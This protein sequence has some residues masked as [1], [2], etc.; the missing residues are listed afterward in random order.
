MQLKVILHVYSKPSFFCLVELTNRKPYKWVQDTSLLL[1]RGI[2]KLCLGFIRLEVNNNNINPTNL[3]SKAGPEGTEQYYYW[4]TL[5]M[6]CAWQTHLGRRKTFA[7]SSNRNLQIQQLLSSLVQGFWEL[8][9]RV[10]V[11]EGTWVSMLWFWERALLQ[12][13]SLNWWMCP[14]FDWSF[15]W[16]WALLFQHRHQINRKHWLKTTNDHFQEN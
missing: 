4:W 3:F 5:I 14:A 9:H 1:L 11:R 12:C 10:F 6:C 7:K 13:K 2:M 8:D 15:W 16:K